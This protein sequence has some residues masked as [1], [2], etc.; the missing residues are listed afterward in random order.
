MFQLYIGE[1]IN[2]RTH[3]TGAITGVLQTTPGFQF[4]LVRFCI[5]P[6]RIQRR[7]NTDPGTNM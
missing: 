1:S 4:M 3:F 2:T 6:K 7:A 5:N